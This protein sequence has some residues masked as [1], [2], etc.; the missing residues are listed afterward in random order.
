MAI[1]T[2]IIAGLYTSL[3]A[4]RES[5]TTTDSQSRITNNLRM[6][7]ERMS[8]EVRESSPN[9]GRFVVSQGTGPNNSDIV[10]FSIPVICQTGGTVIN[11]TSDVSNW[12]APLTWGCASSACMDADNNCTTVDYSQVRYLISNSQLV[13]RVLNS[14][15]GTVNEVTFAQGI[16]DLQAAVNGNIVTLTVTGSDISGLQRSLSV[17]RSLEIYLRNRG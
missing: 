2:F 4:G 5:W 12:G 3:R 13:R 14:G 8:K 11:S 17:T 1:F 6:V 7:M 15:G 9:N 10:T 16:S